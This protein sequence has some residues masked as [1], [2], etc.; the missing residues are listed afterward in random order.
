MN[1]WN[2]IGWILL[3]WVVLFSAVLGF[4]LFIAFVGGLDR[5][6][7]IRYKW[8]G[9]WQD[10]RNYPKSKDIAPA[11]GQKWVDPNLRKADSS[12]VIDILSVENGMI[13]I[14]AY[15][16][17]TSINWTE[18]TAAWTARVGACKRWLMHPK[19]E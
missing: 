4:F 5:R 15:R 7:Q 11:A 19:P 13:T 1:P 18:N 6:W 10:R 9:Y 12:D 16:D 2:I 14:G 8:A 17:G 3:A